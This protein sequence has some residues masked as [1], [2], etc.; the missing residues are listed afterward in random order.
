[1]KKLFSDTISFL[2][3]LLFVY[4]AT[5]K[6]YDFKGFVND[7]NNQPFPNS[8]TPFLTGSIP[9]V[10]ILIAAC[11]LFPSTTI[12]GLYAALFLMLVFST[13]TLL[14]LLNVFPY[15][16]CSCGGIIKKLTWPQHFIFNVFFVLIAAA[17]IVI[18]K[19]KF[20]YFKNLFMH[21]NR[22][23]RKPV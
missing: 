5:S 11:L 12:A 1:M 16:P 14:V 13:Y 23:N 10:E 22:T 9:T 19:N 3:V 15:V 7:M 21:E 4:A 17:G 8:W 20:T 2:L 18:E 6:L